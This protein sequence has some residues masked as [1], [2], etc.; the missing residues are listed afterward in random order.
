MIKDALQYL[1]SLGETRLFDI[2]NRKFSDRGLNAIEDPIPEPLVV[3]TL[4]GIVDFVNLQKE[5][6]GDLDGE[7]FFMH[8][9]SHAEVN[10]DSDL[11][12]KDQNRKIFLTATPPQFDGFRF[13]AFMDLESFIIQV[14]AKFV[15]D[16][17]TAAILKLVSNIKDENV[18]TNADDGITQ[19]VSVRQGVALVQD[20]VVPNPVILRPYRTFV[21]IEQPASPFVFRLRPGGSEPAAALFEADGGRWKLEAI[22]TIKAFLEK[23]LPEV[24]VVA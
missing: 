23:G 18:R 3:H 1:I 4:S 15:Q 10:L 22:K 21:D 17:R 13:G 24:A 2:G 8:V 5:V 20:A 9:I 6:G 12:K 11:I 19:V 7:S 16:E 14:Q